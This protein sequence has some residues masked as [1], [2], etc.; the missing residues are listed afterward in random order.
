MNNIT[1]ALALLLAASTLALASCGEDKNAEDPES[2][3]SY[4]TEGDTNKGEDKTPGADSPDGPKAG[5]TLE[6]SGFTFTVTEEGCATVTS[7]KGES[8]AASIPETVSGIKVTSVG[9]QAF[10]EN[11]HLATVNIP[12]S[13]VSVGDDA[14]G[15]CANLAQITGAKN[16]Y[17]IGS[18]AFSETALLEK[19]TDEFLIIGSGILLDYNGTANDVT[20]PDGVRVIASAFSRNG[21]IESVALPEGV[22]SIC[23][24]AFSQCTALESLNLPESLTHIGDRSFSMCSSLESITLP[25]GLSHI[26]SFAFANC[27]S[28]D[29]LDIPAGVKTIEDSTFLGCASLAYIYIPYT[30]EAIGDMAFSRCSADLKVHC[31][32]GSPADIYCTE[33]GL[34][35]IYE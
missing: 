3:F 14:F 28:L 24:N 16:L 25:K 17:D 9:D 20:V 4:G 29:S 18:Y 35:A 26:G 21:K 1:K 5:D 34:T 7:Y 10:Y 11:Q 6:A 30:V 32:V 27:A 13:V 2:G 22:V 12:D 23:D 31:V 15:K 19:S 8:P 33:N